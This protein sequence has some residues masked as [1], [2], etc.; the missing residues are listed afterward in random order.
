MKLNA[1]AFGLAA[2]VTVAILWILCSLIVV[3][4]PNMSMNMSGYMMHTDFGGM[5]WDMH[6][7]GFLSG[8][9]IWTVTAYA[10][11]GLLAIIY[12]RFV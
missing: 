4:M 5:Q 10:S 12:N 8:L 9:V 2:A 3:T 7:T 11:C 6:L 1:N